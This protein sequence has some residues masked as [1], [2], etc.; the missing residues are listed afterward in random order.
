MTLEPYALVELLTDRYQDRG[1]FAGQI[2]TILE[3]HAD[4]AYEIEFSR[5]DGT[6][7]AWFAAL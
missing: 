5:A 4:E 1:V 7:I 2:G 3:V 6:T